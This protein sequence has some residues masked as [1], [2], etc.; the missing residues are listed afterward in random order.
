MSCASAIASARS[1][2]SR[3]PSR[4]GARELRHFERVCEPRAVVVVDACDENLGF[5]GHAA[6]RGAVDDALA[7]ALVER[8]ERVFGFGVPAPAAGPRRHRV[9]REPPV[10]EVEPIVGRNG[11]RH[12]SL[13][14]F[15]RTMN[16]DEY[17]IKAKCRVEINSSAL[18]VSF[19]RSSCG[20][21]SSGLQLR[22]EQVK[23]RVERLRNDPRVGEDGYEVGV[24]VPS[25]DDVP[26]QVPGNARP[27]RR[28]RGST[29]R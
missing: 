25:R 17:T 2:L 16:A 3:K 15:G 24:A 18:I 19:L 7:V 27:P 29:R 5:A 23:E 4:D 21:S 1:S 22:R 28:G 12:G 11:G 20:S 6:E 10:L 8:A 13:E 14:E 9:R 26:M